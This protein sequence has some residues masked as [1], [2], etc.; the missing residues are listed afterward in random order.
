MT[1]N[2]RLRRKNM[3]SLLNID[4]Q[5]ETVVSDATI[6]NHPVLWI[7]LSK[8]SCDETLIHFGIPLAWTLF[9]GYNPIEDEP[10]LKGSQAKRILQSNGFV[11]SGG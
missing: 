9:M 3:D 10:V 5:Q 8:D 6:R 7:V 1:G 4:I 11:Q 2:G